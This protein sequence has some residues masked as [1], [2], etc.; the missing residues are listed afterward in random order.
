MKPDNTLLVIG[1]GGHARFILSLIN[2]SDFKASGLIDLEDNFNDSDVI[3]G[4]SVVGCLSSINEQYKLGHRDVVLAI[5]DN[6]LRKNYFLDLIKMGFNIPNLIH[7]SSIIDPTAVIGSGNVIGPNVIIGAEVVIGDNNIINSGAVIEHQTRVGNHNHVSVSAIICGNVSIGNDIFLGANSV[8]I[9]KLTVSN[10]TILGA[11]G[12][13][14]SST[15]EPGC[16]LVGCPAR[17]VR[18]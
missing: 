8:V 4:V 14:I 16:T 6:H 12:T 9:D 7:S 5:G 3:M 11:G 2:N 15:K 1:C 13:L 10:D 17:V 18:K